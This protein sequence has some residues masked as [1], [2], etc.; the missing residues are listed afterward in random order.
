MST[1]RI[2]KEYQD[3]SQ[4][5][6]SGFTV[7]LASEAS[8]YTWNIVLA[9]PQSSVYAPGRYGIQLVLPTDYPFKPPV[10]KFVTRIYHPNV[11]NDSLG[12]VCLGLLKSDVW[13]PS[14]R[15][16]AVLDALY[17]LLIEPQPDDPLEERIADEYR[18]N[19]A[20]FETTAKQHV[21]R[22]AL[23]EPVFPAPGAA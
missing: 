6:P 2:A 15:I 12:N 4:S 13:K 11:T 10:V 3:I 1:K 21:N 19:K 22:Y 20:S 7:N 8:I 18:N 5:P 14:T 23:A 17:N 9:P 16:I